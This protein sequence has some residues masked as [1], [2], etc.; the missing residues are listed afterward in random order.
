MPKA[1][2]GQQPGDQRVAEE[3][4]GGIAQGVEEISHGRF[5]IR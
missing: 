1:T 2:A 5:R 3:R 4:D